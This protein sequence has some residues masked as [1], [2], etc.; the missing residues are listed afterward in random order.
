MSVT[1]LVSGPSTWSSVAAI[2]TVSVLVVAPDAIVSIVPVCV[3]SDV[4][5]PVPGVDAT[6]TV[7]VTPE[8]TAVGTDAVTVVE[9]PSVIVSPAAVMFSDTFSVSSSAFVTDTSVGVSAWYRESPGVPELS[10]FSLT[11]HV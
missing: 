4:V 3:K 6:V 1:A 10:G 11:T 8:A 9:P 2:V 5:A 7:T